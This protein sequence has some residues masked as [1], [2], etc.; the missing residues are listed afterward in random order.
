MSF[1]IAD[2]HVEVHLQDETEADWQR[3]KRRLEQMGREAIRIHVELVGEA[4]ASAGM[5]RLN[6]QLSRLQRLAR[7]PIRIRVEFDGDRIERQFEQINRHMETMRRNAR[8][9]DRDFQS[10]FRN[11]GNSSQNAFRRSQ[12]LFGRRGLLVSGIAALVAIAPAAIAAGAALGGVG[13]VAAPVFM[14]LFNAQQELTAA[15]KAYN[16]A[17][18]TPDKLKALQAQHDAWAKLSTPQQAALKG[19]QAFKKEFTTWAG[20]FEPQVLGIF[21]R[22]MSV[23]RTLMPQLGPLVS[24]GLAGVDKILKNIKT[25]LESPFWKSFFSDLAVQAGPSMD[26]LA[27]AV[28]ALLRSIA[29]LTLAIAPVSGLFLGM[30]EGAANLL[31]GL[32]ELS[33]TLVQLTVAAIAFGPAAFKAV[34]AFKA[35]QMASASSRASMLAWARAAAVIG[36]TVVAWNVAGDAS[37]SFRRVDLNVQKLSASLLELGRT[38]R[39]TG[40]MARAWGNDLDGVTRR[41]ARDIPGLAD[42]L[43]KL[44]DPSIG[45]AIDQWSGRTWGK[46]VGFTDA[47]S[48]KVKTLDQSLAQ[49]VQS[50]HAGEASSAFSRIAAEGAKSGISMD[51]LK[52]MFPSYFAAAKQAGVDSNTA[53][54]GI[55][56]MGDKAGD[57]A[58]QMQRLNQQLGYLKADALSAAEAN[59]AFKNALATMN[60]QLGKGNHTLSKAKQLGRDNQTAIINAAKAANDSAQA[61]YNLHAAT[62]D[63]AKATAGANKILRANADALINN[64][65]R[66]GANRQA[67]TALVNSILKIPSKRTS[68]VD[69]LADRAK[70]IIAELKA[71]IAGIHGKTVDIVLRHI[72]TGA[73]TGYGYEHHA[74]GAIKKFAAGGMN[75]DL[76]PHI[77]QTPTVLYGEAETGGEAYIPL[78]PAKRERSEALLA[79]VASMF[80]MI[81]AQPMANGGITRYAFGGLSKKAKAARSSSGASLI[82]GLTDSML[83]SLDAVNTYAAKVNDQIKKYFSGSTETKLL[84]WAKG[85]EKS[86]QDAAKKA[87]GIAAKIKEAR[88]F[89]ASTTTGAK[90]FANVAGLGTVGSAKDILSGLQFRS[91][92]LTDYAGDIDALSKKGVAKSLIQQVIDLGAGQG[93]NLADTL[94]KADPATLKQINEAQAAID[95]AA[96]A[97]GNNAADAI[98]DSGKNASKGFLAG[99]LGQQKDLEKLADA[100]AAKFAAGIA[101]YFG[102]KGPKAKAPATKTKKYASGGIA[103]AGELAMV[104]ERGRELVRFGNIGGQIYSARKTTEILGAGGG[105]VHIEGG[106]H[107]HVTGIVDLTDPSAARKFAE[108]AAPA[109]REAIRREEAKYSR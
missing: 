99:L 107:V 16:K 73:K 17:I 7:D 106:L 94:L 92:Q 82:G 5:A 84:K 45:E 98:Y 15:T 47:A 101:K 78:G 76:P 49:L 108:K 34:A 95:K 39:V 62:G 70:K 50:G 54:G 35:M 28:G 23:G 104:G 1:R 37:N 86:M 60:T 63:T 53:A 80:G 72:A 65:V 25:G 109:M 33:P 77:V 18:T 66:A 20:E 96:T 58:T 69:V 46:F 90:S 88:D 3:I 14:K 51:K 11:F 85:I 22:I 75:H 91:G 89:A 56:A 55:G 61:Y 102:V 29:S 31:A 100:M 30:I 10:M 57:A 44:A 103:R 19:A 41:F 79:K 97:V 27:D 42:A 32:A 67:V 8:D 87:E 64:A 36:A 52:T 9:M 48:S 74:E 71:K 40:E 24:E 93:G 59:I 26:A 2:G 68:R 38:G 4:E 81:V 21:D 13:V 43:K 6:R 105:G 12:G 83:A